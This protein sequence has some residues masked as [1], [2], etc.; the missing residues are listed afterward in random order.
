MTEVLLYL[1]TFQN[2]MDSEMTV[3]VL[4]SVCTSKIK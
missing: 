2:P 1:N 3:F 4:F